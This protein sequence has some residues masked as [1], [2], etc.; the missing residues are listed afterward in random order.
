MG[1]RKLFSLYYNRLKRGLRADVSDINTT[2]IIVGAIA[3][4]VISAIVGPIITGAIAHGA[5][6]MG[7]PPYKSPRLDISMTGGTGYTVKGEDLEEFDGTKYNSTVRLYEIQISN[8][9]NKP[10][11]DVDVSTPLPGCV[12][13]YKTSGVGSTASV[14]DYVTVDLKGQSEGI[15]VY[16][17][18]KTISIEQLDPGDTVSVRFLLLVSFDRCDFLHGVGI[19]NQMV[20]NYQWQKN[21]IRFFES[22]TRVIGFD[23]DF[24]DAFGELD[25]PVVKGKSVQPNGVL[26]TNFILVNSTDIPHAMGKCRLMNG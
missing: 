10:I 8:P 18:S 23:Q 3:A 19:E 21:G 14:I 16:S 24:R 25:Y 6:D 15:D 13:D 20:Y 26:Y 17:C 5:N 2:S 1:I 22:R 4:I 12:K 11:Q 9:G 7:I